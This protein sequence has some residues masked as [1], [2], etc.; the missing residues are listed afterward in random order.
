MNLRIPGAVDFDGNNLIDNDKLGKLVDLWM[1][2]IHQ[3][4]GFTKVW[5]GLK[6]FFFPAIVLELWWM[7]RRLVFTFKSLKFH[8]KMA[9]Y[10]Y[11]YHCIPEKIICKKILECF[12]G[13][14]LTNVDLKIIINT[15]NES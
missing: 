6:T 13:N 11:H 5:L 12:S 1:I 2:S 8:I 15:S 10:T 3:N 9:H 7:N 14:I 4:G